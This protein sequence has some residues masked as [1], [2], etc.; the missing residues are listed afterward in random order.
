MMCTTIC[1]K[2]LRFNKL[3]SVSIYLN[4]FEVVELEIYL[5][6]AN[7]NIMNK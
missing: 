1:F 2:N 4:M 3:I 6:G 7:E 5:L